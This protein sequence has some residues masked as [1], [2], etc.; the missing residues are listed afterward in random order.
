MTTTWTGVPTN[1]AT[2][3]N[4]PNAAFSSVSSGGVGEPIGLLLALTYAESS[5]NV[6]D[7][8]TDI[9]KASGSSWTNIPKAT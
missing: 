1:S 6:I 2:Y 4:I 9:S 8:W 3:T 7:P 5:I